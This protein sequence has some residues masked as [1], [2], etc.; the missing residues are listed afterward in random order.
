MFLR[1]E[2][3]L[4]LFAFSF[5]LTIAQPKEFK[6]IDGIISAL[7]SSISGPAG[8]RDWDYFRS[9]FKPTAIMGAISNLHGNLTYDPM[10]P[11]SYIENN[12]PFFLENGFWE[13]EIG[14]EVQ[15]FGMIAHVFSAYEFKMES[16]NDTITRR[17]INSIQ[18]VFDRE[19][20]WVVSLQWDSERDNNQIPGSMLND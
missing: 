9:L 8:E 7:Y 17:G 2:I 14:R 10:Y 11:K 16:E 20:W 15:Q 12:A 4:V 19:R 6:T 13:K 5:S 18:L 3:L 1:K